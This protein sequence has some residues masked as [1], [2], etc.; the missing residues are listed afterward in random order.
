MSPGTVLDLAPSGLQIE[1]R[2]TAAQ[3][4]GELFEFD[5]VGRARGF[6][7]QPHVHTARP[8]ATR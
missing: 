6:L 4:G 1:I 3:T 2:R 7:A 8:S 5:V